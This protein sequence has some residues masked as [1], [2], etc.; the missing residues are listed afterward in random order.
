MLIF[1]LRSQ[2]HII[3]T[4]FQEPFDPPHPHHFPFNPEILE[5]Y[6]TAASFFRLTVHFR[7]MFA[8]G[9]VRSK[10]ALTK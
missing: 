6:I 10:K 2:F 3:F 1:L 8:S 4:F 7:S 5:L 9:A